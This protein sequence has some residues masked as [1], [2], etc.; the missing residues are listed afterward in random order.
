[1]N[2]LFK[3]RVVAKKF[4]KFLKYYKVDSSLYIGVY[5]DKITVVNID[6]KECMG[7]LKGTL[8][9]SNEIVKPFY[10][11]LNQEILN[12]LETFPEYVDMELDPSLSLLKLID[13]DNS[14]YQYIVQCGVEDKVSKYAQIQLI[15]PHEPSKVCFQLKS[16]DAFK[17]FKVITAI[18]NRVTMRFYKENPSYKIQLVSKKF[19]NLGVE[20]LNEVLSFYQ[21][22]QKESFFELEVYFI[23]SLT[24]FLKL[25]CVLKFEIYEDYMKISS[26]SEPSFEFEIF[27]PILELKS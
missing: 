13:P 11:K 4:L 26:L 10:F 12:K 6:F 1:M 24:Q 21:Y 22:T 5:K 14:S 25:D 17:I 27:L 18:E 20:Y 3:L 7:V 19:S 15:E 23:E 2:Q 16:E 8:Y 9:T